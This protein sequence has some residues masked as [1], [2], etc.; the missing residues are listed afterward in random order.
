MFFVFPTRVDSKG[1]IQEH[2]KRDESFGLSIQDFRGAPDVTGKSI[3]GKLPEIHEWDTSW[4]PKANSRKHTFFNILWH[5][6]LP[7]STCPQL[8]K[9][10]LQLKPTQPG[11]LSLTTCNFYLLWCWQKPS[12]LQYG[13]QG[14]ATSVGS[15]PSNSSRSSSDGMLES[16]TRLPGPPQILSPMTIHPLLHFPGSP[17]PDHGKL[18]LQQTLWLLWIQSPLWGPIYSTLMQSW[19]V[20][21]QCSHIMHKYTSVQL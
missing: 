19:V 13:L 9:C 1:Y 6:C 11:S 12:T 21:T 16:P 2:T 8:Q 18:E 15:L 7:L 14:K 3:S 17:F 5:S 10:L 20:I 4:N